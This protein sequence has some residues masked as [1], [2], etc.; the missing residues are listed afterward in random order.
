MAREPH[1]GRVWEIDCEE[2]CPGVREGDRLGEGGEGGAVPM[3][4]LKKL[5]SLQ[6]L[7]AQRMPNWEVPV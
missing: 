3:G 2:L 5:P 6:P 1:I 4:K 7:N